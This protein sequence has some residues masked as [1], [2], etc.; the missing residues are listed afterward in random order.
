MKLV[1]DRV[2]GAEDLEWPE[3]AEAELVVRAPF[4]Q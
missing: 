3:V 4:N 2:D 1:G